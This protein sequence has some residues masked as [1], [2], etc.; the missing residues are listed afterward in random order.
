MGK[1][2]KEYEVASRKRSTL[3]FSEAVQEVDKK[4]A[5]DPDC[6]DLWMER[7]L[8]LSKQYLFR[9]A[10]DAYS[11]AISLDPFKGIYY[12]HRAHRFISCYRFEDACADFTIASR[13]IPLNWDVWYHLGLSHFLLGAYEKAEKA[14]RRCYELNEDVELLIAISNWFWITLQ[15]LGKK[16][17]A[18][19][20]LDKITLNLDPGEN[21][22]YY[23]LLKMYKKVLKPEELLALA[24]N[25]TDYI[26]MGFGIANYYAHTGDRQKSDEIIDETLKRGD[27]SGVYFAFG[28]I[29]AM[30]EKEKRV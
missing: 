2:I 1:I 19:A 18:D 22:A 10:A 25:D 11:R 17:E 26:T 13:L 24:I 8:A 16:A 23:N 29:T 14:Y 27:S 5:T 30:V 20:V 28:Y 12:R 3:E 7:G 9:A 21:T 4:L 6:P 15:R